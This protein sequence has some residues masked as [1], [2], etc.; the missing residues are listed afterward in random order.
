MAELLSENVLLGVGNPLL[1]I[2]ATIKVD[3]LGRS[4]SAHT[5]GAWAGMTAARY[6]SRRPVM[7]ELM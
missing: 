2:S 5:E 1:D 3:L 6:W 7:L 4:P